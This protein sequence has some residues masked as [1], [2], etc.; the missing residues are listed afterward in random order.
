MERPQR[1]GQASKLADHFVERL[2]GWAEV[3]I[4]SLF[5]SIALCREEIVFA[6][7]WQGELYLKADTST[8]ATFEA[9][10]S[11]TLTY[12]STGLELPQATQADRG[13][14]RPAARRIR[15]RRGN[16]RAGTERD[17]RAAR[18]AKAG[19]DRTAGASLAA[20]RGRSA[21]GLRPPSPSV[22]QV[23]VAQ[24]ASQCA[25]QLI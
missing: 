4:R 21:G 16:L 12:S 24:R 13:A 19:R 6:L 20:G 14:S 15:C 2:H 17:S 18:G 22:K 3:S 7:V 8:R 5:G 9:E 23:L 1:N 11:R 25:P 10:G